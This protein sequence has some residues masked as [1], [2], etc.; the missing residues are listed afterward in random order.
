MRRRFDSRTISIRTKSK[1]SNHAH[2]RF[3]NT[4][5][6]AEW[7]RSNKLPESYLLDDR[8]NCSHAS[9]SPL[10]AEVLRTFPIDT[11]THICVLMQEVVVIYTRTDRGVFD[12]YWSEQFISNNGQSIT[13]CHVVQFRLD[14]LWAMPVILRFHGRSHWKCHEGALSLCVAWLVRR[15]WWTDERKFLSRDFFDPNWA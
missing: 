2:N 9:V 12:K 5:L 1:R 8:W 14:L 10:S 7:M 11:H 4:E 6:A 15:Q 3:R 13:T